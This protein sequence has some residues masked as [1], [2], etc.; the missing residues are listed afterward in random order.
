ML[1]KKT[2][3]I[4]S[5]TSSTSLVYIQQKFDGNRNLVSK[6]GQFSRNGK[7]WV[8]SPHIMDALLPVIQKYGAIF[9][10]ELYNHELH[11]NFEKICSLVK[12]TRPTIE[13]LFEA[14]E[15][16]KYYIYDCP[17]IDGLTEK[18]AFSI[19]NKRMIEALTE[20]GLH[21]HKSIVIVPTFVLNSEADIIPMHDKFVEDGYEG[22]IIRRDGPYECKRSTYLLKYK[23]FMDEEFPITDIQPGRGNKA[24]IAARICCRTKDGKPFS[25]GIIGD[26][27][28]CKKLLDARDELIG[29]PVTIKFFNYTTD[30]IPRFPKAKT[31]RNYE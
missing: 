28:Y 13:D 3:K 26:E 24:N 5:I 2:M 9:D 30:G 29:Q 1:R 6:K 8:A 10:G 4:S 27:A 15:L 23:N 18:V 7:E 20:F 17:R 25:A 22:A 21:T 16:V 11:D 19:R 31:V 14:E 12:K